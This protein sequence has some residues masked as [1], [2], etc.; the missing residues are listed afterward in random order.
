MGSSEV[1]Q[2]Q[3]AVAPAGAGTGDGEG[4][5]K[6]HNKFGS[7]ERLTVYAAGHIGATQVAHTV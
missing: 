3:N 6:F 2:A 5:D 1:R 7:G 4:E